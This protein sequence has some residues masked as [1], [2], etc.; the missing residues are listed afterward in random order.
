VHDLLRAYASELAAEDGEQEVRTALTWMFDHYLH[1]AA[2][3]MDMLFPAEQHR[4]P[5]IP[6]PAS[7]VP[8]AREGPIGHCPPNP[9]RIIS[10]HLSDYRDMDSIADWRIKEQGHDPRRGA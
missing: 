7:P 1:T 3:A 2:V 8:V 9:G 6:K 10:P 4:R 5:R